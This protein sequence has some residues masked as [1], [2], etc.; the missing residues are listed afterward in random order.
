MSPAAQYHYRN[1][2]YNGGVTRSIAFLIFGIVLAGFGLMLLR[3]DEDAWICTNGVWVRHGHPN[4]PAPRALCPAKGVKMITL[5]S[6][7]FEDNGKLPEKY[8]CDGA[9]IS[10]PLTIN[11]T[12]TGTKSYA[13]TVDDPDAPSGTFHHWLVWNIQ[14]KT[15]NI[16]ENSVP[17]GAIEGTNSTSK[18][19]YTA[20]CPPTGTH[21]YIFTIYALDKTLLLGSDVDRDAFD[22]AIQGHVLSQST[23]TATYR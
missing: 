22:V 9:G 5:T 7:A 4:A 10:P 17:P 15:M 16:P 23:L 12:V 21:R 18:Q 14:P 13:L 20:A 1:L 3:G 6:P 2:G 19:S 8:T 11:G